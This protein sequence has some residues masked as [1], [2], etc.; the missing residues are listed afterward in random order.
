MTK[1]EKNRSGGYRMNTL[2][3]I[4]SG[5]LA[6]VLLAALGIGAY[7]ALKLVL[8]LF[9]GLEERVGMMLNAT[10]IA[11]AVTALI[12]SIALRSGPKRESMAR[13]HQKKADVYRR[14]VEVWAEVLRH[15]DAENTGDW[16][17]T[18]AELKAVE[19]HLILWGSSGVI[20]RYAACKNTDSQKGYHDSKPSQLI[21]KV[22]L[23]M[24]KDLG[25]SN[26]GLEGGYLFDLLTGKPSTVQESNSSSPGVRQESH[27]PV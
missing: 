23:E 8:D 13:L 10:M 25:Q 15:K 21:E 6:L 26:L 14:F 20:K 16:H 9:A 22:I 1:I 17:R 12:I 3:D 7:Y 24:R 11:V 18:E 27:L 5:V 4:V 2:N 19:K